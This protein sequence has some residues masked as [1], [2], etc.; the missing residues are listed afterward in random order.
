[1]FFDDTI[2][3]SDDGPSGYAEPCFRYLNR[4]GRLDVG[5]IRQTLE[6]WLS[7]YPVPHQPDLRSRFRD[8]D[9]SNH[10]G[11]FFELFLHEILSRLGCRIEV[12]PSLGGG[13]TTRPDFLVECPDGER[14]YLEAALA[15]GESA[16][17]AGQRRMMNVV[18]D[19]LNR[20]ESPN[21]FIGMELSGAPASPP[22][23]RRMR[24]F[25][26]GRLSALDPDEVVRMIEGGGYRAAPHWL[27]EE[28][29]WRIVF[30][31]F[32]KSPGMRGRPGVRPLGMWFH[33]VHLITT[34]EAIRDAILNKAG[35]YGELDLP[36]VIAVDVLAEHIDLIQ[37]MEAL[38]GHEQITVRWSDAG[39]SEPELGRAPNGA[40]T[41]PRGP[42][43]TRVSA[44]LIGERVVPSSTATAPLCLYHN[45]WAASTY[46]C[47]LTRFPQAVPV[48]DY[49]E[50]REGAR[51]WE[52]LGLPAD[53]P[54]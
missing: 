32:P 36:Y 8:D 23:G 7:R 33:G 2:D 40:W 12:H 38:F 29:G 4:S 3:R 19:T 26:E 54:G 15:T 34:W 52:V 41:S 49:M 13:V 21:F 51:S 53:W 50:W 16:E 39:R 18:Y 30:F 44:V 20:M 28:S 25:L 27:F 5:R 10:R 43:N 24:E 45:P 1:M 9:D 47:A 17:E 46:R 14:F 31:P 11:A 42:R 35:R 37:V 22:P 6:D 48:G